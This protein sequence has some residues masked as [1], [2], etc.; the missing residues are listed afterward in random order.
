M[1]LLIQVSCK[2]GSWQALLSDWQR[3]CEEFSED[4]NSFLGASL[5]VVS[6]LAEGPGEKDAGVFALKTD[7]KYSALCQLN[8]TYLPGYQGKVLRAR[9]IVFSPEFEFGAYPTERYA[10]ELVN[11][12][13]GVIQISNDVLPSDHIKFHLRSPSDRAFFSTLGTALGA[14]KALKKVDSR[15]MWLYITK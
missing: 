4:F 6:D 1:S 2:D 5:S 3:Q 8:S 11:L 14:Q 15:G 7:D 12:L 10:D 9:M 13:D